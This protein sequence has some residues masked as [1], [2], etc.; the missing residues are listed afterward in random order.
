MNDVNDEHWYRTEATALWWL[1]NVLGC[2]VDSG[3]ITAIAEQ[4]SADPKH[5][6]HIPPC[7]VPAIKDIVTALMKRSSLRPVLETHSDLFSPHAKTLILTSDAAGN[8]ENIVTVLLLAS[9]ISSTQ[10]TI[11]G[12]GRKLETDLVSLFIHCY[13]LSLLVTAGVSS[14]QKALACFMENK[15]PN[16]ISAMAKAAQQKAARNRDEIDFSDILTYLAEK[17]FFPFGTSVLSHVLPKT[18][19]GTHLRDLGVM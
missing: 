9:A 2:G 7:Y 16:T 10:A 5:S 13:N 15:F 8:D 4:D 11:L 18:N 14:A 3:E 1:G 19:L 12:L 6:V 17:A